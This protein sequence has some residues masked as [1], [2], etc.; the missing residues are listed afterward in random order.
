MSRL[1]CQRER[2]TESVVPDMTLFDLA[3]VIFSVTIFPYLIGCSTSIGHSR[4]TVK[5]IFYDWLFGM[6]LEPSRCGDE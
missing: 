1:L 6:A 4:S 5:D 3:V 2:L